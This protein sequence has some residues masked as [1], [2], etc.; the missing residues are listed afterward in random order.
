MADPTATVLATSYQATETTTVNFS[1]QTAGTLL[2]LVV[3]ADDY[4]TG[5]PSGWTLSTGCSQETYLGHYLWWKIASGSETS[6]AYTIGSAS[7]SVHALLAYTN[8]EGTPLDVSNG[9]KTLSADSNYTTPSVTSTSGR[10]LAVATMGASKGDSAFTGMSTWLSSFTE[11]ADVPG[12]N[13]SGT[14]DIIGV[15]DLV[16]D[17][18]SGVSSGATYSQTAEAMTGIIAVFKVT[19]GTNATVTA[20]A[21]AAPAAVDQSGWATRDSLIVMG[22]A[23]KSGTW[24]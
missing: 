15:A 9:Q 24:S 20:T 6:V 8:I 13:T 11:R 21:V 3:G 5:D 16:F 18:G 2:V 22:G 7:P 10:R 14:R 1:A 4:K 19:A 12:T 17:G 23:S